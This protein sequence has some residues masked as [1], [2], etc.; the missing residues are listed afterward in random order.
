M[1][2]EQNSGTDTS[3]TVSRRK[4]LQHVGIGTFIAAGCSNRARPPSEYSHKVRY[5]NPKPPNVTLPSYRGSE[6]DALVPDSLDL[7]ERCALAT[8]GI[9]EAV[10]PESD[11]ITWFWLFVQPN[12]VFMEHAW[13]DLIA[14]KFMESLPFL[15]TACGSRLNPHVEQ[16]W[17]ESAFQMQGP[18]GML[19]WPAIGRPWMRKI[20][21]DNQVANLSKG[22]HFG[23][24]FSWG[25]FLG[26]FASYYRLTGDERFKRM[27]ERLTEAVDRVAT[28]EKGYAYFP[29]WSYE[30]GEGPSKLPLPS[31]IISHQTAWVA[32][33]LVRFYRATGSTQALDLA[34]KLVRALMQ[35]RANVYG[36]HGEFGD[37]YP[38]GGKHFHMHTYIRLATAEYAF[39][40]A[41]KEMLALVKEGF[42]YGR[43]HGEATTGW[44]PEALRGEKASNPHCEICATADMVALALKLSQMGVGDY[45]DD[46]DAWI[47]NNLAEGQLTDI[48][49]VARYQTQKAT[50]TEMETLLSE[51]PYIST[52]RPAERNIGNFGG[53]VGVNDW[54]GGRD[55]IFEERRGPAIMQCCTGN[56]SMALY[57]AFDNIL[58]CEESGRKLR[59]NLLLNRASRWADIDSHMPY[60]GRVDVKIKKPI[61]LSI[62][63]PRWVLP[64]EARF[65]VDGKSIN[66]SYVGRYAQ[67]GR[68]H[69]GSVATLSFPLCEERKTILV[70]CPD[71]R[72]TYTLTVRGST[73]VAIE[74]EGSVCSLY[75]RATYRH[76]ETRYKKVKRFV[77]DETIPW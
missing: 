24:V 62:R 2:I 75:R 21:R 57:C 7:A 76:S 68:L 46:A 43:A 31:H 9:T 40:T 50:K 45:W 58:T 25:R 65:M 26:M 71:R 17:V 18:D 11:Y 69:E 42:E 73:V 16:R 10:D 47:R 8:H 30:V 29:K 66:V 38:K 12:L 34:G 32:L 35:P 4:F 64:H 14:V 33:G 37:T 63:V 67:L 59:V 56:G 20:G 53:W 49:W 5:I 28:H 61:D 51:H 48:S 52:V 77:A 27:G 23:A 39:T 22:D 36:P 60:A 41:D 3:G 74:P 54:F 13:A 19:Y 15:R 55:Y 72:D 70:E 1:K 44:F 6:Y